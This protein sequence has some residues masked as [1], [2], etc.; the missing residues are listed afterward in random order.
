MRCSL[1]R[2]YVIN[3]EVCMRTVCKQDEYRKGETLR[4]N[5]HHHNLDEDI[6]AGIP[7]KLWL[8]LVCSR[9]VQGAGWV[10]QAHSEV[11]Q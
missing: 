10:A 3:K 7:N 9:A 6:D 4:K 1:P 8:S 11:N 2:V 5:K